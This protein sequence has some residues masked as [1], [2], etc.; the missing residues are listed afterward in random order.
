MLV[1]VVG[2][3]GAIGVG[4]SGFM[5]MAHAVDGFQRFEM[6]CS[7]N[8]NLE[9]GH[10]YTVYFEYA[11]ASSDDVP[12]STRGRLKDPSGQVVTWKPYSSTE[13]YQFGTREGRAEYSFRATQSGTYHLETE[14]DPGETLAIGDG[15]G[16]S[17]AT[18]LLIAALVGLGGLL[19]GIAIIVTAVVLRSRTR[20][21]PMGGF[22]PVSPPGF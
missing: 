7:A 15:L 19:V 10:D 5:R 12:G 16:S 8:V 22:T 9:A 1:I 17:I 20:R 18:T 6:P 11:G 21:Q 14:G 3:A 2:F 13:T 4:V